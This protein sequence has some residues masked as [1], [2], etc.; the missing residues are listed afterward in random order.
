M[1]IRLVGNTFHTAGQVGFFQ[2][3]SNQ[4]TR[5]RIGDPKT[6]KYLLIGQCVSSD[7][8]EFV[9]NGTLFRRGDP[10][11]AIIF[12]SFPKLPPPN[13]WVKNHKIDPSGYDLVNKDTGEVIFG[14]EVRGNKCL[15][16]VNLYDENGSTIARTS[17]NS[18]DVLREPLI[19]A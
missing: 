11:A 4:C 17:P 6:T 19:M 18:F 1:V 5:F 15:I 9:F 10:R 7:Q 2:I 13:G 3:G 14:Y 12:D 16:T 8:I